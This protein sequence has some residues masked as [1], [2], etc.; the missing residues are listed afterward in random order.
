MTLNDIHRYPSKWQYWVLKNLKKYNVIVAPRQ[1][2]KTHLI[3]EIMRAVGFA[4]GIKNPQMSLS[5][6]SLEQVY[7]LYGE[8]L[9]EAF[10]MFSGFKYIS[11]KDTIIEFTRP[12]GGKVTI[13]LFGSVRNVYGPKGK[14]LDLSVVDEAGLCKR[15]HVTEALVP[16]LFIKKGILVVTGTVEPN[17]YYD[18]YMK[19]KRK[20]KEGSQNWFAFYFKFEDEWS[21][22]C[23]TQ[24]LRAELKD[25]Y[26]LKDPED[27][28]LYQKELL[29]NWLAG[30]EGTPFALDYMQMVNSKRFVPL[31][32]NPTQIY[33]TTW[34]NGAYDAIWFWTLQ[35]GMFQLVDFKSFEDH[36]I[37]DVCEWVKN[38][39]LKNNAKPGLHI[40][41]H[42]MKERQKAHKNYA[43]L[44]H[45]VKKEFSKWSTFHGKIIPRI[46]NIN[47]KLQ[48]TKNLLRNCQIDPI[49][50][51]EGVR[52]LQMYSRRVDAK[53]G[54]KSNSI[55]KDQYS[56]GAEALGE[57]ALAFQNGWTQEHYRILAKPD[58]T[59]RNFSI[60]LTYP[61][62]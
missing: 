36:S 5:C 62:S 52:C 44:A 2:G 27:L 61:Y 7:K 49:R 29:C 25:F 33:G 24:V 59:Y 14:T 12:D 57:L 34:D 18:F 37:H 38:W 9:N 55:K 10:G 60:G 23:T 46:G 16:A 15:A 30:V 50:C 48:A 56:H 8:A 41:P 53:S 54:A 4:P 31:E 1:H 3:L 20:M 39:Y 43:A 26:D 19:A 32:I 21:L 47:T 58:I 11:A 42:T 17:W 28:R 22:S 35:A 13:L 40:F 45:I 51:E 6:A